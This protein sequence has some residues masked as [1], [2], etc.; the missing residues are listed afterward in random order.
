MDYFFYCDGKFFV[1]DVLVFEIVVV[2][3]MLFYC[4]FIV[5]FE[6]YFWLF[7]EVLE[8]IEYFV[9]YVMKV[10]SN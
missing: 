5:M 9:C 3:G 8:G 7:D 2:V 1:E 6:C 4:Y 10:V